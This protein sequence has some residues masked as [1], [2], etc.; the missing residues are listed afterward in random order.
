L[1][2]ASVGYIII[3]FWKMVGRWAIV[4]IAVPV[5]A[6]VIRKIGETIERRRGQTRFS[7]ILRQTASGLDSLRRRSG[8]QVTSG[9]R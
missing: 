8:R 7:S 9:G 1:D 3:V 2:P 5:A 4:A 6:Y